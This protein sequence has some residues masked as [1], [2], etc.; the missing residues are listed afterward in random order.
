M[1]IISKFKDYY[2]T[3]VG[4]D[5]DKSLVYNRITEE[6]CREYQ[7][8]HKQFIE[9]PLTKDDELVLEQV[10][11]VVE[12]SC[13][14]VARNYDS[15][16]FCGKLYVGYIIYGTFVIDPD[17]YL[18][19][20]EREKKAAEALDKVLKIKKEI[21]FFIEHRKSKKLKQW[22]SV[23][24]N[25]SRI[26]WGSG[27][28]VYDIPDDIFRHFRSPVIFK[29]REGVTINP[30][31]RPYSFASIVD[32][33]AAYQEISMFLGNNLA[34]QRDPEVDITDEVRAES[35]GFDSWSF[36]KHKEDSKKP[37]RK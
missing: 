21:S 29:S 6:R 26:E 36:R 14:F 35:K 22:Y 9:S 33:Y 2:D 32:P 27:A 4:Y 30:H 28:G 18:R 10:Y 31:L 37:R 8:S 15:F 16:A 3:A 19:V 1:R 20:L 7:V 34:D 24:N 5:S 17:S 13:D 23:R 25:V 11:K 12:K